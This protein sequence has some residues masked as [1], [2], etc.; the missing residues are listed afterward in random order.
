MMRLSKNFTLEEL[1]VTSSGLKNEPTNVEIGALRALVANVLQP[2][3]E[4]IG[5]PIKINSG[6]RSSAVNKAVGGAA[7]SQHV[8]GEAA[9]IECSNNAYL[10]NLIRKNLVFDQLIWEHGDDK[11]PAWVHVSYKAQGNRHEVLRAKKVNGKTQYIR[12]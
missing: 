10:F 7:P 11:Q 2:L 1:C 9:D 12:L 4:D 6:F 8:K 5:E 3:R